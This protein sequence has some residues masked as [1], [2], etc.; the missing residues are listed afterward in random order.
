MRP[1]QP[2]LFW[3]TLCV[4][5]MAVATGALEPRDID[6]IPHCFKS[7]T[8]AIELA[9]SG[10]DL[11]VLLDSPAVSPRCRFLLQTYTDFLFILSYVNLWFALARRISIVLGFLVIAAGVSDVLEN[12]GILRAIASPTLTQR[13][14]DAIRSPSL[15]KWTCLGVIFLGL[16]RLFW[17]RG[18]PNTGW[19]I[20]YLFVGLSYAYAG[21]L[22]L[23]GATFENS[24][25]GQSI[26]PLT[27]A[28]AL[29]FIAY[30]FAPVP[31]QL[32]KVQSA[33]QRW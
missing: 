9:G 1:K 27:T 19:Q 33:A 2:G 5:V 32:S 4:I 10:D 21:M 24:L 31:Q 7:P 3:S 26:L 22:C 6:Y 29:Q 13:L 15:I 30:A 16:L 11:K 14:A 28:L 20:L 8:L 25:I 17:P 12:I 18:T 23:A